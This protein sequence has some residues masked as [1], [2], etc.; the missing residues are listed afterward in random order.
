[1]SVPKCPIKTAAFDRPDTCD[2]ECAKLVDVWEIIE[3]DRRDYIGCVCADA[4][5]ALDPMK[6]IAR[7]R[8]IM[9]AD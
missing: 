3:Y 6:F 4:A 9:E 8:N 1:M 5:I 2:P 7:P